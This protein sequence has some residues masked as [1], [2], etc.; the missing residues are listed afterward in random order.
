MKVERFTSESKS[1][2][3]IVLTRADVSLF[4]HACLQ[5]IDDLIDLQTIEAS[6]D[7]K[8]LL[9]HY[10]DLHDGLIGADRM[11]T[12]KGVTNRPLPT[13]LEVRPIT[14]EQFMA[15]HPDMAERGWFARPCACDKIECEGWMMV[16]DQSRAFAEEYGAK[17]TG[18][19]EN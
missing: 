10:R 1:E 4:E 17:A 11:M 3:T 15:M 5:M 18:T 7:V 6:D 13:K 8:K 19:D 16:P 14:R 12:N 2:V 9:A